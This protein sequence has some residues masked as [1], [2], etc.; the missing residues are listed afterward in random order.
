MNLK[1]TVKIGIR[2]VIDGRWGGIR[3]GLEEQTMGMAL[4]FLFIFR[5]P[6]DKSTF[7]LNGYQR[8][9]L[10]QFFD[11]AADRQAIDPILHRHLTLRHNFFAHTVFASSDLFQDICHQLH[12]NCFF[13]THTVVTLLNLKKLGIETI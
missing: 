2:P 6:A 12:I 13:H 7:S 11:R 9:F 3:E 8:A 10:N 5:Q 4:A 1:T